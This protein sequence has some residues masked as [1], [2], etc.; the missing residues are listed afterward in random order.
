[1][2]N[3]PNE[4]QEEIV[5][6]LPRKDQAKVRAVSKDLKKAADRVAPPPGRYEIG[7]GRYQ[8]RFALKSHATC[9]KKQYE[10]QSGKTFSNHYYRFDD[11]FAGNY[12]FEEY[13]ALKKAYGNNT[14]FKT[15]RETTA[16]QSKRAFVDAAMGVFEQHYD[17]D[18]FSPEEIREA[19]A[20]FRREMGAQWKESMKIREMLRR[21][22]TRLLSQW[23]AE[24]SSY[25]D[26]LHLARRRTVPY[27]AE[28]EKKYKDKL[29]DAIIVQTAVLHGADD[30]TLPQRNQQGKLMSLSEKVQR[31]IKFCSSKK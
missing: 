8:K 24:D 11:D 5:R 13:K 1:M 2:K 27:T 26:A 30:P 25:V 31:V 21:R 29:M 23:S 20:T 28:E 17:P 18:F 12:L 6:R 19:S 7:T 22:V 4:L 9:A 16:H 3:L 14:L 10:E 15:F